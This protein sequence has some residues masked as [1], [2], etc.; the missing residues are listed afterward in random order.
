MPPT[1]RRTTQEPRGLAA[2]DAANMAVNNV[3]ASSPAE[4]TTDLLTTP[5]GQTCR[6]KRLGMVGIVE[7]GLL[8]DAD[9]LTAFVDSKHVKRVRGGKGPDRDE[10]NVASLMQ[11]PDE[12]KRVIMLVDRAT[13]HIVVEPV[14]RLHFT[15]EKDG[16][17][18]RIPDAAREAGVVYTDQIGFED[19]M[20]LFNWAVGGTADVERFRSESNDAVAGVG[21]VSGVP[22]ARKSTARGTKRSR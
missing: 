6:A 8:G 15:D 2:V 16:S 12:L 3:W 19:K 10:I 20:F 7:S 5:S 1:N 4:G 14:V 21:N 11:D 22:R 18:L 9:T 13:P 17:T